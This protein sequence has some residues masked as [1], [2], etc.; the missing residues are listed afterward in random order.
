MTRLR[1]LVAA[2]VA[3]AV[4]S[5]L[6]AGVAATAAAPQTVRLTIRYDPAGG[7]AVKTATLRCGAKATATGYLRTSAARACRV[8]RANTKLLRTTP[9]KDRVCTLIYGGPQTARVRGTIGGTTIDRR[10]ARAN[11]CDIADWD[12]VVGLLPKTRGAAA[13]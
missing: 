9:P 1:G 8:A 13:G 3:C 7:A 6:P 11:G 5:G 12:A 2:A 10:F 4:A